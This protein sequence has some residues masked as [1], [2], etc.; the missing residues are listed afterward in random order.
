VTKPSALRASCGKLTQV[1]AL[2]Q[3][4][5]ILIALAVVACKS[6]PPQ[7]QSTLAPVPTSHV[8]VGA[9]TQPS[10]ATTQPS[11]ATAVSPPST[12]QPVGFAAEPPAGPFQAVAIGKTFGGKVLWLS[13][14]GDRVWL[15]GRGVDAFAEGD[16]ELKKG[17]D[18][19]EKLPY[20]PG[21]HLI[22]V[23]G[24]YPHLYALRNKSVNGRVEDPDSTVFV[25]HAEANGPGTWT[26][27]KPLPTTAYPH[28]FVGFR[29]GALFITGEIQGNGVPFHDPG[30]SGTSF[31][32]IAPDGT[33]SDPKLG[34]DAK[35]MAWDADADGDNLAMVGTVAT[36]KTRPDQEGASGVHLVRVTPNGTTTTLVQKGT[37]TMETYNAKVVE[38]NGR[39]T[40]M[41]PGP[42]YLTG[43]WLPNVRTAFSLG[44]NETALRPITFTARAATTDCGVS[45][46]LHVGNAVYAKRN[47]DIEE[48][49]QL[50][51]GKTEAVTLPALTKKKG[52]G[53]RVAET[54]L[55]S[56][57][58]FACAY[59][60]MTVRGTSDLWVV[61]E[62]G[63]G[64][65]G[66]GIPAVFRLG[67]G[68]SSVIDIP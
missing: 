68:Q 25:F 57:D 27:S 23:V 43:A 10:G 8:F 9:S 38:R 42:F 37:V 59:R 65:K 28:A 64:S 11:G 29:G 20:K 22:H 13:A 49:V 17:S 45:Q 4:W 19:L 36:G 63:I 47:C 62:C 33:V 14:H 7:T 3:S 55:E 15:S 41:F 52:G 58:G 18:L 48:L 35:F 12:A 39:A 53:Y 1:T 24:R 32:W 67:R 61:A 54:E 50:R 30:M 66:G 5:T 26:A 44:D 16:G 6:A 60:S 46:V 51:G 21:V 56:K 40:V 2:P 31:A 34:V